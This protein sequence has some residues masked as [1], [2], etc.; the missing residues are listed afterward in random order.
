ML[1]DSPATRSEK[2]G[3]T[4]SATV[5]SDSTSNLLLDCRFFVVRQQIASS[6]KKAVKNFEAR[7]FVSDFL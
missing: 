3:S 2:G 1:Y 5:S 7:F 6:R 4:G